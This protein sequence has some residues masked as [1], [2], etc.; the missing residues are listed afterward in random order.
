MNFEFGNGIF[1]NLEY[2]FLGR[3][4]YKLFLDNIKLF[5]SFNLEMDFGS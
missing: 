3:R 5:N 2:I 4:L 1:W